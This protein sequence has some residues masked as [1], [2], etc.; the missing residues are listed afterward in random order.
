MAAKDD[1]L[2]D[3][4]VDMAILTT[5]QVDEARNEADST[6]EGV[7]DTLVGKGVLKSTQVAQAKAA[8]FG[9]EYVDLSELKLTDDV[10]ATVPRHVAKKFTAVPVYKIDDMTVAIALAD[11]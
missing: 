7:I 10:I 1:F 2:I 8:N 9:V 3:T 5:E 11:P 6:G 4:L